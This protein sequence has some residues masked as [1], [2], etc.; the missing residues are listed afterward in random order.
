MSEV[1][2]VAIHSQTALSGIQKSVREGDFLFVRILQNQGGGKYLASF[3]GGRFFVK[4][5]FPLKAG[6][7]FRAQVK[8]VNG[9]FFLLPQNGSGKISGANAISVQNFNFQ[10]PEAS[11]FVASLGLPADGISQKILQFLMQNGAR[12]DPALMKKA[13]RL[14]AKFAGREIDA[15]ESAILLEQKGFDSDDFLEEIME[16]LDG[17]F[18]KGENENPRKENSSDENSNENSAEKKSDSD[19]K[20]GAILEN[21]GLHKISDLENN[22]EFF[23][24]QCAEE[25]KNFFSSAL[26]GDFF[27]SEKNDFA[28]RNSDFQNSDFGTNDFFSGENFKK[29]F[30]A[31]FNQKAAKNFSQGQKNWIF[32]PFEFEMNSLHKNG[33]DVLHG[34]GVFRICVDLEKKLA[35]KISVNFKFAGKDL[36]FV[37][38]FKDKKVCRVLFSFGDE[39][40]ADS[41]M[42]S[43]SRIFGE[44][45]EVRAISPEEFSAFGTEGF[46]LSSVEGFA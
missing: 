27:G 41:S 6:E 33:E 26:V 32:L 45:V 17:D 14:A 15:S 22:C 3:A 2:N 35:E 1:Q 23:L 19:S 37:L 21:A 13:R 9:K 43:L 34:A 8:I 46:P 28:L 5:D 42:E 24:K 38:C 10:S 18:Q 20:S 39:C 31:F 7:T 40:D 12:L 11:A 4:S 36:R 30:L 29:N 16:L 25:I 44:G